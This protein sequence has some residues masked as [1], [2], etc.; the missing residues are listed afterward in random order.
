MVLRPMSEDDWALLYRWSNDP[1]VLYYVE[2]DHVTSR[3]LGEV[4]NIVRSVCRNAFCFVI[5]YG[6]EAIGEC[7]LQ[8]MNLDRISSRFPGQDVRRI[9]LM[10]GEKHL[11]DRESGQ[12]S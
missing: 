7:W 11:G 5:E 10:I 1:E 12:R 6:G 2:E 3:T 9:D 8:E 4:Q